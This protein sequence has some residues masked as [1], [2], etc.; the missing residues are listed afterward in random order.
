MDRNYA[1]SYGGRFCDVWWHVIIINNIFYFICVTTTPFVSVDH[2]TKWGKESSAVR[3]ISKRVLILPRI[4]QPFDFSASD[5][6]SYVVWLPDCYLGGTDVVHSDRTISRREHVHGRDKSTA[7]HRLFRSAFQV[8]QVRIVV[9]FGWRAWHR[10]S[11]RNVTAVGHSGLVQRG[12]SVGGPPWFAHHVRVRPMSGQRVDDPVHVLIDEK[13]A[14]L[15]GWVA[16]LGH[17]D[18]PGPRA[19]T[20]PVAHD[21]I[22]LVAVAQHCVTPVARQHIR[23]RTHGF[24]TQEFLPRVADQVLQP[25]AEKHLS[26]WQYSH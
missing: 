18:S 24:G 6:F 10:V 1:C 13:M 21:A 3:L 4:Y 11:R 25:W 8:Y 23:R 9:L 19:R 14:A 17:L 12:R 7:A 15:H 22:L 5:L 2:R 16:A 20:V 26:N